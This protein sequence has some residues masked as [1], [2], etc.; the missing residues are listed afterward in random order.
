MFK[1]VCLETVTCGVTFYVNEVYHASV[2][3]KY[4][5]PINKDY[6]LIDDEY[7]VYEMMNSKM[8]KCSRVNRKYFITLAEFRD[9]I[10][11]DI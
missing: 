3:Q 7:M 6:T 1:V 10:I 2:P 9:K 11:N 8:L 4:L 5:D